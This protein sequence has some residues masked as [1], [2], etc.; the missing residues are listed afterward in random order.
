VLIALQEFL[1]RG[2]GFVLSDD[3][4]GVDHVATNY[5]RI[6][7]FLEE[8]GIMHLYAMQQSQAANGG[9]EKPRFEFVRHDL[10]AI[11]AMAFWQNV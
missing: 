9:E 6:P 2:G 11:K 3:S 1:Q 5:A 4:H 7:A 10:E 8:V